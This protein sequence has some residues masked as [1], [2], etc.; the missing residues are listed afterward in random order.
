MSGNCWELRKVKPLGR[1]L[2]LRG[3]GVSSADGSSKVFE[4]LGHGQKPLICM[5]FHGISSGNQP[6]CLLKTSIGKVSPFL[7]NLIC[8]FQ[9]ILKWVKLQYLQ[10]FF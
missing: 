10:L 6:P 7:K 8:D 4:R 5:R 2:P 9:E 3:H 1:L